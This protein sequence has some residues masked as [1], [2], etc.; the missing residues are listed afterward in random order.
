VSELRIEP[1]GVEDVD[2][3]EPL[4]V[5]VHHQHL[6]SMPQLGPYVDDA[7]TWRHR[8][9]LYLSLFAEHEPY[10]LLARDGATLVGY[11]LAYA[12]PRHST[13]LAD[14][15]VTGPLVGEIESLAVLPGYPGRGIGGRLLDGLHAEL[16]RRGVRDVVI[17]VL[18]GNTAAAALCARHGYTPTW[19]YLSRLSGR[20]QG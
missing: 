18:P 15:W 6:A 3:L 5:G 10:L 20:A 7:E 19:L 8:R 12:S 16:E 17:G 2:L 14:T 13:W 4:W 11:G 9:T 1:G